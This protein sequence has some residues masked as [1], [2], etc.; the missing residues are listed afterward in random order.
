VAS[1]PRRISRLLTERPKLARLGRM[2]ERQR[3]LLDAVRAALPP[4]LAPHCLHA[5][6][7]GAVL[8]LHVDSPA[9]NSRLRFQAPALLA[10]LRTEAPNLRR[11]RIRVLAPIGNLPKP[12]NP[13]R[14]PHRRRIPREALADPD[15]RAL[16]DD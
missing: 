15:L 2:L 6:I 12:G 8:I 14:P 11:V 5:R 1:P 13:S 9:W 3:R 4:N 16:L 10:R 7:E